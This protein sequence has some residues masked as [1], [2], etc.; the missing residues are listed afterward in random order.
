[1]WSSTTTESC[2]CAC[3]ASGLFACRG[4]SRGLGDT[5]AEREREREREDCGVLGALIACV[6]DGRGSGV[7]ATASMVVWVQMAENFRDIA[8]IYMDIAAIKGDIQRI[9][10]LCK[11]P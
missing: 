8:E 11:P 1:M 9:F 5:E 10:R 7:T 3:S 4:L 2:L 6:R